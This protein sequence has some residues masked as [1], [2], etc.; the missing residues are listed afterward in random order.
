MGRKPGLSTLTIFIQAEG[1]LHSAERKGSPDGGPWNRSLPAGPLPPSLQPPLPSSPPLPAR[2]KTRRAPLRG[3]S[4]TLGAGTPRQI[5]RRRRSSAMLLTLCPS[6]RHRRRRCRLDRHRH[7]LL[8]LLLLLCLEASFSAAEERSA[9]SGKFRQGLNGAMLPRLSCGRPRAALCMS[10]YF[11][12]PLQRPSS[13][14][15]FLRLHTAP[16]GRTA[17]PKVT[18]KQKGKRE[19]PSCPTRCVPLGGPILEQERCR[20]EKPTQVCLIA[21]Q[22]PNPS[23]PPPAV[24]TIP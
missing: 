12:L 14:C 8:S 23:E 21:H 4:V 1:R 13:A 18:E 10:C 19:N 3:S 2:T 5:G 6:S 22:E 17:V 16:D 24:G 9:M 15:H 7:L 11:L 20:K